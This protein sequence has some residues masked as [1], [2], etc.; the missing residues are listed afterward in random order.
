MGLLELGLDEI[1]VSTVGAFANFLR[2]LKV[3]AE[4][5]VAPPAYIFGNGSDGVVVNPTDDVLNATSIVSSGFTVAS[6]MH[7]VLR[8]TEEIVINGPISSDGNISI[9][10]LS[11]S[12]TIV[13]FFGATAEGGSGG[14]G[15]GGGGA[16][17][18]DNGIAGSQGQNGNGK[19]A[20]VGFSQ[21][22]GSLGGTA[23][24][25]GISAPGG[26]G[27]DATLPVVGVDILDLSDH[28]LLYP[29]GPGGTVH[30]SI[31]GLVGADGKTGGAA[32]AGAAG[33][34][35]GLGGTPGQGAGSILLV[36]PRIVL[37]ALVSSRGTDG[38]PGSAG[39]PG[40][41][42]AGGSNGGGGGGGSGGGGG[43][44]GAGGDVLAFYR[45]LIANVTPLASPGLGGAGALGGAGGANDGTGFAGGDGGKGAD[46]VTG[47]PGYVLMQKIW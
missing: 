28:F 39:G 20:S 18:G 9:A 3:A 11:D 41:D 44:G 32:F 13:A 19:S 8:A 47:S 12:I 29:A 24:A 40:A 14:S 31:P 5:G 21:G 17:G 10:N 23:G 7:L 42:A 1:G 26:K 34:T 6:G 25:A 46:G 37:N 45:E 30:G 35:P 15:G 27:G 33:G 38:G 43:G 36:A 2:R 22:T 16:G 4:A